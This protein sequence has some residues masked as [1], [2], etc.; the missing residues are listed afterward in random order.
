MKEADYYPPF[1][2]TKRERVRQQNYK[3]SKS[4]INFPFLYFYPIINL[5]I[6]HYIFKDG[7]I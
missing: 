7:K 1:Q 2:S 5:I 6:Q 4:V 3:W